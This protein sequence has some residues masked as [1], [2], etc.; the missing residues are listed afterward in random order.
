MRL[1]FLIALALL[2]LPITAQQV[3]WNSSRI[4]LEIE[5]LNNTAS[6]LYIAAHPDDENTRLIT[7]LANEQRVRT[8]YLSLTRGDGGQNLIGEEQGAYLGVIRTQELLAARR[9][10]GGEQ[11]FTRA[12][13]FGYSKTA[14]ETFEKWQKDSI[15]SDVVWVIRNFRPDIIITRFPADE[16]A[17]HGHH[18]A[19]AM[20]AEE[21]F[22]AAADPK[23]FPEQLKNVSVWQAQRLFWNNSTWWDKDLPNKISTGA[24]ELAVFDVGGYN[25]LLGKSYGE[26]AAESRTNHKSQGFGSTPTRGEQKEYL[27]LKKG[28]AIK[29]ANIFYGIATDW[30]RYR[31]GADLQIEIDAIIANF[32]ISSPGKAIDGL[33]RVY[34]A[35]AAMP[36]DQLIEYKKQQVQKIIAACLGLWLEPVATKDMVANGDKLQIVS[37]SLKRTDYPISLESI[38]V[39]GSDYKS[40]EILPIGINQVDTFNIVIPENISSTPYWLSGKYEGLFN[41]AD[42]KLI[43]KAENDPVISFVYHIKIKD[44]VFAYSRGVVFKETD[45]VKGEIYKPLSVVPKVIVSAS[46]YNVLFP[47]GGTSSFSI[48]VKSNTTDT[49]RGSVRLFGN[50]LNVNNLAYKLN[51]VNQIENIKFN[52]NAPAEPGVKEVPLQLNDDKQD[53]LLGK[54]AQKVTIIEYDHIPRQ[55]IIEDVMVKLVTFDA[56][57]S[58]RKIVYID[59]AGDL[60]D[61]SLMA[62][63]LN[64]TT[65][66]PE[67]VTAE[68]LQKFD[69]AIIGVRAYNTAKSM[70]DNHALLMQFANNGGVVIAQYSTNWDMYIEQIGPYPFKLTRSRV[71]DENSPV[72]FL[73]PEH[74][75]LNTPNKISQNDFTGWIQERGIYFAGD[76]APE[77]QTPLA[78]T[79]PGEKPQAGGLIIADYGKGAFIY[80]GLAFFREL[81]AGVPGAYRLM[82]NMIDYKKP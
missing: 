11:Y 47:N 42:R 39:L 46:N 13:D 62:I 48:D 68:M 20:L 14:T 31:Q 19:S 17:G 25:T 8:G 60:V 81:P 24:P 35:L 43:G 45:A 72:D 23:M 40:G 21:A 12:V 15:L 16:R 3:Q 58:A 41:V 63:G 53:A 28:T 69:V 65:V 51:E 77:Y 4:L 32:D 33:L 74:P 5:K 61:E 52:I 57:I 38:T 50:K 2:S 1:S 79:D 71:T 54:A 34:N 59:G 70:I 27:E 29:D 18:T 67:S 37:N 64:I 80:T 26:I 6:V 44:N 49:V 82:L 75:I 22:A 10:D 66:K 7:Y 78:F 30:E 73:L 56:A 9:L 55:V 76:L 36:S